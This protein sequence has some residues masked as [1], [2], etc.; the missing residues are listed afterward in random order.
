MH[1]WKMKQEADGA[2]NQKE[3]AR[4]Q[5][6]TTWEIAIK[7]KKQDDYWRTNHNA[8]TSIDVLPTDK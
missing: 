5:K 7:L 8:T 1:W 6:K 4:K 3:N 2:V